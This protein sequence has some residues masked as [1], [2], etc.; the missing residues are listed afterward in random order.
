MKDKVET[1]NLWRRTHDG[2]IGVCVLTHATSMGQN[3]FHRIQRKFP[4]MYDALQ[5]LFHETGADKE[6]LK[7]G[8]VHAEGVSDPEISRDFEIVDFMSGSPID[9]KKIQR[10]HAWTRVDTKTGKAEIFYILADSKG[11]SSISPE[12]NTYGCTWHRLSQL[13]LNVE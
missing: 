10:A 3:T 9:K 7:P 4:T 8:H 6:T 1:V 13:D 11:R 12:T 5:F 2:M